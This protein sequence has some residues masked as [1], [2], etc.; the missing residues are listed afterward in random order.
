VAAGALVTIAVLTSAVLH[1]SWNAMAHRVRDPLAAM[2]LIGLGLTAVS[3]PLV[4]V[5]PFPDRASWPYLF[6]SIG[7]QVAY[8]MLLA[9]SYRL[10]DFGQ[11]YPIARG[12]SPLVVTLFATLALDERL[13]LPALAGVLV[14]CGGLAALVG[15]GWRVRNTPALLAA[16]ATGL[17]ISAYTLVDGVGVRADGGQLGYPVWLLAGAGLGLVAAAATVYRR[18]LPAVLAG[19]WWMVP[20][21]GGLCWLSYALVLWAQARGALGP[22]AALRE[23][24]VVV[25]AM[26]GTFVFGERFGRS[27]IV[28]TVLVVLGTVLINI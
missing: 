14:V 23:T 8:F 7:L 10:G 21:G 20:V 25:A 2:T 27:R 18:R 17:L 5:V 9:R 22:V 26:L 28:A 16:V 4:L 11:V 13:P 15:S 3:L 24:S 19:R 6:G 12:M 1:A